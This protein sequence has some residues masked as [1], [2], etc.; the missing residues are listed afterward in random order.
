VAGCVFDLVGASSP[1]PT[2]LRVWVD[3]EP[4]LPDPDQGWSYSAGDDSIALNGTL[5]DRLLAGE[6]TR[7]DAALGCDEHRCVPRDEACDGL[8]DDCD[9]EID[10]DC[11]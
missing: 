10:E 3:G 6:L 2:E 4:V 8:D 9:G 5:C 7:V 11:L 1:E